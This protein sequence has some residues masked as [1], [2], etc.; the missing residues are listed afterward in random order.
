MQQH[1]QRELTIAG[2]KGYVQWKESGN[3]FIFGEY[4]KEEKAKYSNSEYN[5]EDMF[6]DQTDY[7]LNHHKHKDSISYVESAKA[8]ITIVAAAKLSMQYNR[9]ANIGS[10]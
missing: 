9:V 5:N 1:T 10:S 3:E 4:E 7:F 2:T 8:S 6:R